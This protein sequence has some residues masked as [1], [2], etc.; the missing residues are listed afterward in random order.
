[1]SKPF[2]AK[3]SLGALVAEGKTK[4]IHRLDGNAGLVTLVAKQ[5]LERAQRAERQAG[6]GA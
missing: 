6:S 1:M 2:T 3:H 5:W 4:K